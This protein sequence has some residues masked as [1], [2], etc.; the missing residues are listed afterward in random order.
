MPS[1]E[2]RTAIERNP[3]LHHK[4]AFLVS[5]NKY[6]LFGMVHDPMLLQ[7]TVQELENL[8]DRICMS[9]HTQQRMFAKE[10]DKV[11][12]PPYALVR[13]S[14][15]FSVKD[16]LKSAASFGPVESHQ[17]FQQSGILLVKYQSADSATLSYGAILPGP[18]YFTSGTASKDTTLSLV[19]R[20][21]RIDMAAMPPPKLNEANLA[22]ATLP[23]FTLPNILSASR[24]P[25]PS[26]HTAGETG[27]TST[28]R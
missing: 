20:I 8:G 11:V 9:A 12:E 17:L 18:V 13:F 4:F 6:D 14:P 21:N 10:V 19:E 1:N 5:L 28:L 23:D 15:T 24:S 3:P 16:V 7:P 25:V 2:L 27:S 22:A 26:I